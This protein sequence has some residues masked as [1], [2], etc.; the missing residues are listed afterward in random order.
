MIFITTGGRIRQFLARQGCRQFFKVKIGNQKRLKILVYICTWLFRLGKGYQTQ[1]DE[2]GFGHERRTLRRALEEKNLRG[3]QV[4]VKT[5][6][7][8]PE[9][10]T[11]RPRFLWWHGPC[12]WDLCFMSSSGS[13]IFFELFIFWPFHQTISALLNGVG[14]Q[15]HHSIITACSEYHHTDYHHKN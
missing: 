5:L 7:H 9:N 12:V 3:S 11:L 10:L 8:K 2:G 14:W 1:I 4:R 13:T 15:H 6:P